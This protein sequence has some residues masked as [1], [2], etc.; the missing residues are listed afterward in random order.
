M[1]IE[2][3]RK[4]L[5]IQVGRLDKEM[6]TEFYRG[7]AYIRQQSDMYIK[8]L[9]NVGQEE[10]GK[11]YGTTI[12][13]G[14]LINAAGHEQA[15]MIAASSQELAA[16]AKPR[17]DF[18]SLRW[19]I[20]VMLFLLGQWGIALLLVAPPSGETLKAIFHLLDK[21]GIDT[22]TFM[23]ATAV[24]CVVIVI[25]LKD[26]IRF[27]LSSALKMWLLG[28]LLATLLAISS[29]FASPFKEVSYFCVGVLSL[30]A[31][32]LAR[33]VI[34]AD[35]PA[36]QVVTPPQPPTPQSP[37]PKPIPKNNNILN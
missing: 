19:Q 30:F 26:Y 24:V 34:L 13:Q 2:K 11:I 8:G 16:T 32:R 7:S 22:K 27:L 31:P 20:W 29:D 28:L 33:H 37:T 3:F 18:D 5:G 35:E 23:V 1:S 15:A 12:E 36:L 14:R 25:N 21:T 4:L 10:I 6:E 9:K 17:H